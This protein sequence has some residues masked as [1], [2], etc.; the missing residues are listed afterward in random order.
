MNT[1]NLTDTV[2]DIQISIPAYSVGFS[3]VSACF[4]G[5]SVLVYKYWNKLTPTH[6]FEFNVMSDMLVF[7]LLGDVGL[8]VFQRYY[9]D[10][11]PFCY[12]S[13]LLGLSSW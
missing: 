13:N 8:M 1:S 3:A 6:I 10:A 9:N 11:H 12:V 7:G 2:N 4:I 5:L